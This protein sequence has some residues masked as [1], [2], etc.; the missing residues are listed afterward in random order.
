MELFGST[1]LDALVEWT[2]ARTNDERLRLAEATLPTLVR[3]GAGAR[4]IGDRGPRPAET[5]ILYEREGCPF[6]RRVREAL[7]M[8]DLD[9]RIKPVPR[10]S[11]RHA[12]ELIALTGDIEI[13]VMVDPAMGVVLAGT[14]AILPHLF[15]HYGRGHV[16]LRLRE[17]VTSKLASR[18]RSGRGQDGRPSIAPSRALEL[19]GYEAS[20]ATRLV[21][22]TL[23]ELELP[24]LSRP[25]APHSPRRR[26]YFAEE[27]TME[28]PRLEDPAAGITLY[29]AAAICSY[30]E[31][32]YAFGPERGIDAGAPDERT[33]PTT[34]ARRA[35]QIEER[36]R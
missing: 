3:L 20:P 5:L 26:A 32:T 17:N 1:A 6:S 12:R 18:L 21:R 35:T 11:V 15:Q 7:A 8:L 30:L 9:A 22:E 27:G 2:R 24:Y 10:G 36:P 34:Q 4:T 28:L 29:G 16:P 19:T 23:D 14:D 13:P 33:V 25:L 31:R